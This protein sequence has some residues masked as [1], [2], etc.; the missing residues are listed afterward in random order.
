MFDLL[1]NKINLA[2]ILVNKEVPLYICLHQV[3]KLKKKK[4]ICMKTTTKTWPIINHGFRGQTKVTSDSLLF[5]RL[6]TEKARKYHYTP[7]LRNKIR[8][9]EPW[10]P[11]MF[12][13]L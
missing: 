4:D 11:I 9:V 12:S 3:K 1:K 13:D 7:D 5:G 8:L 6:F 10:F 2:A